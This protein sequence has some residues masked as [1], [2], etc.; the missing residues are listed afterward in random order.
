MFVNSNKHIWNARYAETEFLVVR[1]TDLT[2]QEKLGFN[3]WNH[4]TPI[5]I[6]ALVVVADTKYHPQ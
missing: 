1:K 6:Y 3:S 5:T 2:D 4:V